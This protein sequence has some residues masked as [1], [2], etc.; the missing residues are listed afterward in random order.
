VAVA[1]ALTACGVAVN[2]EF[3]GDGNR[4][5]DPSRNCPDLQ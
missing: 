5:H 4:F 1:E 2:G 3:F